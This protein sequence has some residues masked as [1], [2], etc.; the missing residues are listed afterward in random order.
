MTRHGNYG[1]H[2]ALLPYQPSTNIVFAS[3]I[4]YAAAQ[5]L[6]ISFSKD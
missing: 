4:F 2:S 6:W 1:F 3:Y 5:T